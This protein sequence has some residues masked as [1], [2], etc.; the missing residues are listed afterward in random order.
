MLD[1]GDGELPGHYRA[2]FR[3]S[4]GSLVRRYL[5]DK[6]RARLLRWIDEGGEELSGAQL[7]D[8]TVEPDLDSLV[9]RM[10]HESGDGG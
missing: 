2:E 9:A 6:G 5:T 3:A 10:E 4:D 7:R 1:P 8:L